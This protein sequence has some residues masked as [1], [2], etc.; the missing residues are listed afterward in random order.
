MKL[1]RENL[2]AFGLMAV[3]LLFGFAVLFLAANS[4]GEAE[5]PVVGEE[6]TDDGGSGEEI[7]DGG[8][9]SATAL[10]VTLAEFSIKGNLTAA[11]GR[12]TI[13][14]SNDGAIPHNL[15]VVGEAKTSDLN[16]GESELLTLENLAPGT[17]TVICDIPGHVEAG[18]ET[19]LVVGEGIETGGSRD[20]ELDYAAIDAAFTQSILEFPAET[21]GRGNQLLEPEILPDGTLYFELTAEITKWET[22]PGRFVDAWT[23]NGQV[24]GPA[25]RIE[26]GDKV[27]VKLINKLPMGTDIHWHGIRTPNSEDGVAPVTQALIE[28]GTEYEY[29]FVAEREAIGMFHAHHAAQI[30]VPNGLFGIFQIGDTPIPRGQTIS[31]VTIPE[32]IEIALEIPMVLNDSGVIGYSLN[33][34][35][36]PATEPYVVNVGDWVVATYYNEGLQIHPMH[37][38]QFPQL[39]IAKDGIALDQPYWA[40]TVNVAPGERYTVLFNP[41]T[42]GTWVWHCHILTHVEREDGVF[43]MLTAIIVQDA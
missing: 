19:I 41:D 22:E 27:R 18:M 4:G 32:D 30:Q 23:Y 26:V 35:S 37:L 21:E 12:V 10:S 40:D 29:N 17:Y 8:Q 38:H 7:S 11:P 5:S 1:V 2:L 6:I 16:G 15:S 13:D 9:D 31:G 14:V 3:T 25:I 42:P 39:I 43:G 20:D 36:F 34:K 33:G 28:A 24:P